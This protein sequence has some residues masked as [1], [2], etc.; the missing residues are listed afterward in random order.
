MVGGQRE[1][2][3]RLGT[4]PTCIGLE[5]VCASGEK[6]PEE[7]RGSAPGKREAEVGI[8]LD[9]KPGSLLDSLNSWREKVAIGDFLGIPGL[10]RP[11]ELKLLDF[12]TSPLDHELISH[13]MIMAGHK[14][15]VD[16][17]LQ[18]SPELLEA[19]YS[20]RREKIELEEKLLG[21]LL[22]LQKALEEVS[23]LQEN[24]DLPSQRSFL[25]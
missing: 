22:E 18:N 16:D 10:S 6:L 14:K 9:D 24:I 17:V 25:F 1:S 7:I 20:L 2:F 12:L 19:S 5:E 8:D 21:R 23:D 3:Q 4:F 11:V 13:N 15:R